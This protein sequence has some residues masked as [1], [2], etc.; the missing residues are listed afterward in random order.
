MDLTEGDAEVPKVQEVL[1]ELPSGAVS[2]SGDNGVYKFIRKEGTSEQKPSTGSKVTV[3][4]TGKL[5]DGSVFD[6]SSGRKFTFNLGKSEVIKAWDL[7]VASMKRGEVCE[8]YCHS[9]YA[10]G[11]RGSPP[12]IPKNANLIFEVELHSWEAEDLTEDKDG[13][14]LREILN[15]GVDYTMPNNGAEVE[16]ELVGKHNDNVFDERHITYNVSEADEELQLIPAIDII[17]KQMKKSEHSRIFVKSKYGFGAAGSQ[18]FNIPPNADLVYDIKLVKFE[19]AAEAWEMTDE[20]RLENS[21]IVKE[22]GTKFFKDKKY[23][24]A[25]VQYKKILDYLEHHD[26]KE[27]QTDLLENWKKMKMAGY[28]NLALCYNKLK[29]YAETIH[30]C[31]Q[32][33]KE[34]PKSE[35]ALYRMGEAYFEQKMFDEAQKHFLE[36]IKVNANNKPARNMKVKCDQTIKKL[37]DAERSKYKGMF[38]KFSK[39]DEEAEIR[40]KVE[41]QKE[42]AKAKA[43]KKVAKTDESGEPAEAVNDGMKNG[44]AEAQS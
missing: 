18:K 33:L 42:R 23:L 7:G 12:K 25:I 39:Q 2:L 16:L 35:K 34:D 10:Y 4:Y 14:I 37:K 5:E 6:S 31:E 44:I 17:V 21:S 26:A 13:G 20:E 15:A 9:K 22:K 19:N 29:D 43:A 36:V 27:D 30:M 8:L 32:A 41:Q 40:K 11:E 38:D 3:D 1:T 28:L 24:K